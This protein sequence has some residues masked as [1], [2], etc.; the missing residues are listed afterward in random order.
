MQQTTLALSPLAIL[1][2][3]MGALRTYYKKC[4]PGNLPLYG[5][6]RNLTIFKKTGGPHED[7]VEYRSKARRTQSMTGDESRNMGLK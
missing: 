3:Q 4:G 6:L 1:N 2:R 5:G 7:L